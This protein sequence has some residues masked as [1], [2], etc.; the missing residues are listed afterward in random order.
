MIFNRG[1]NGAEELRK[2]TSSYYAN[3]DFTKISGIVEQVESELAKQIG[4]DVMNTIEQAYQN[5]DETP[6]VYAAQRTVGYMSVMRYFRLNDIS[7]ET[8][9]RKVKMDSD[10]E[11][12][13]FEW[14]LERDDQM[15]LEEYYNSFDRLVMLLWEDATF[16]QSELY[17]RIQSLAIQSAGV[18]EWVTGIEATPHLYLRMVPA[19]YEAQ[20]YVEKRLGSPFSSVSDDA[21]AYLFQAATGNR[22]VALFVQKTEMQTLPS[23]AFR[24]AVNQSGSTKSSTTD[25]LHDFYQHVLAVSEGYVKDMQ[26][27]RDVLANAHDSHLVVPK[28][29]AENKYFI[30]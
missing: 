22:A 8:D 10:N 6:L 25:Q 12:R 17:Q 1:N 2:V 29:D 11:R 20:Q 30:L 16:Q 23:G 15:H 5:G 3:A 7:H 4:V 14:Q 26:C 21:L 24:V 28:N 18:L 19:L 9:G 13:P 27:R